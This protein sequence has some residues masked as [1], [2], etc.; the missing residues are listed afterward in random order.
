MQETKAL[1]EVIFY[2]AV[3][4]YISVLVGII[5]I[6]LLTIVIYKQISL[7]KKSKENS[8]D[9]D[10]SKSL[11]NVNILTYILIAMIIFFAAL[12]LII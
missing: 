5:F 11:R 12:W 1:G 7:R 10:I 9:K 2:G 6:I 3:C 8:D 4:F